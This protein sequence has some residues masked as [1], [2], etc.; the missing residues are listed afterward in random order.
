VR[1]IRKR[2]GR[3]LLN[4]HVA[5]ILE[6]TGGRAAGV[7]LRNGR[8]VRARKAV[9]SNASLWDAKQLV[10]PAA[11]LPEFQQQ[12]MSDGRGGGGGGGPDGC[13]VGGWVVFLY[14]REEARRNAVLKI[15]YRLHPKPLSRHAQHFTDLR[16]QTQTKPNPNH[17]QAGG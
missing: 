9:V 3:V 8:V 7:R 13:L 4:A 15:V 16:P 12:V 17:T 1:A 6:D 10:P 5:R 2:G 11:L 14:P